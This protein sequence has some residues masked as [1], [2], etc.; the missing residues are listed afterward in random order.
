M[1]EELRSRSTITKDNADKNDDLFLRIQ[2]LQ[3]HV[4]N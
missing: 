2:E 1:A 3:E 4:V